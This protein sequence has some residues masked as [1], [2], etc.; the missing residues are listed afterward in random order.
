MEIAL[1][2]I[3]FL[4]AIFLVVVVLLQSGKTDR[5]SGAITGGSSETFFGKNKGQSRDKLLDKLIVIVASV[6]VV[7][8]LVVYI[9]QDDSDLDALRDNLQ[10]AETV[11]TSDSE[12]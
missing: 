8:V 11:D 5:L 4:A 2:I 12:T 7:L 9:A 6:F 3:L 1:S 10:N